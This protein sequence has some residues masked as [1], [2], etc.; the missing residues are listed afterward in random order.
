MYVKGKWKK[1]KNKASTL[2]GSL[3]FILLPLITAV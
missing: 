1:Q 2:D 3:K